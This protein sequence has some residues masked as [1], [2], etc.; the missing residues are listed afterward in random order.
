[1]A[2]VAGLGLILTGGVLSAGQYAAATSQAQAAADLAALSAVK[3]QAMRSFDAAGQ[4]GLLQAQPA[5]IQAGQQRQPQAGYRLEPCQLA[6]KIISGQGA[7]LTH[8]ESYGSLSSQRLNSQGNA[9]NS[10]GSR[11]GVK[12][13]VAW[14][15]QLAGFAELKVPARAHAVI[16]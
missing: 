11:V 8:C 10:A 7:I 6:D 4:S 15:L 13:H 14:P 5:G 9:P 1:M 12:L 3:A 16:D 2:A